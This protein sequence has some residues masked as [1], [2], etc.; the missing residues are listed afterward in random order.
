MRLFSRLQ[1]QL[2]ET[3][4]ECLDALPDGGRVSTG[5]VHGPPSSEPSGSYGYEA[6]LWTTNPDLVEIAAAMDR[7]LLPA[8][9]ERENLARPDAATRLEV[10][11]AAP[12]SAPD[13]DKAKDGDV[14]VLYRRSAPAAPLAW[15]KG[16]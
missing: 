7:E 2:R 3:L 1:R 6:T 5:F 10:A 4:D 9:V 14:F 13:L 11:S 12:P 15:R 16:V 8:R